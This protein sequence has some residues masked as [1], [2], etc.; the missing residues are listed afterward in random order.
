MIFFPPVLALSIYGT[1]LKAHRYLLSWGLVLIFSF[2]PL[3]SWSLC[4]LLWAETWAC[5][6]P[7]SPR[8][9]PSSSTAGRPFSTSCSLWYVRTD[10]THRNSFHREASSWRPWCVLPVVS[11]CGFLGDAVLCFSD[12]FPDHTVL[13]VKFQW[14]VLQAREVG[15]MPDTTVSARP[16]F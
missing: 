6:S 11:K 5:F 8:S 1:V 2:P 9:W 16:F 13:S 3:R 4:G 12:H 14:W 15:D 10:R 7:L